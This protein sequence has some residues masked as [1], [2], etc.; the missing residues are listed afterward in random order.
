MRFPT[1]STQALVQSLQRSLLPL[2]AASLLAGPPAFAATSTWTGGSSSGNNFSD[3]ANWGGTAL[4]S[5]NSLLFAGSTRLTPNNDLTGLT[6]GGIYFDAAAGAFTLGGN[7]ITNTGNIVFYGNNNPSTLITQAVNFDLVIS[8]SCNI[9]S[10]SNG[11]LVV[12][13]TIS[14]YPGNYSASSIFKDNPGHVVFSGP[15]LNVNAIN[16]RQGNIDFGANDFH[17]NSLN[18]NPATGMTSPTQ[19][20]S[21]ADLRGSTQ[22]VTNLSLGANLGALNTPINLV[23][24]VGGGVL[25][26]AG[27]VTYL[28]GLSI[29]YSNSQATISAT[30][31]LNG[32]DRTFGIQ[33]S[34]ATSVD[35]L[36]NGAIINS[37]STAGIIKNN[38][39]VLVLAGTNTY[40]GSTTVNAG[41]LQLNVAL[42]DPA[43]TVSVNNIG[44]ANNPLLKLNF[45]DT[46]TVSAFYT[47]YVSL[48]DGV[49][50]A[51]NMPGVISGSGA[52]RVGSVTPTVTA[53]WLGGS[54]FTYN[55]SGQG[56][57]LSSV[58]TSP[59]SAGTTNVSYFGV[60][61][62]T[63]GPSANP[64]T[65]AGNYQV[66]VTIGASGNLTSITSSPYSFVIQSVADTSVSV[67]PSVPGLPASDQYAVRVCAA[68]N[69]SNWQSAFAWE[70]ADGTNYG[71]DTPQI[72]SYFSSLAGWTHTYV[73]FVA[74]TPVIVE[75][76]KV[77][78][79]AITKAAVH[80]ARMGSVIVANGKAYVTLSNNCNVAVDINGQMDDN[81]TG[82]VVTNPTNSYIGHYWQGPPINTISIHNNPPL[83]GVPATNDPS[84]YLV[85]PGSTPP[86]T[87]S[88]TTLYFLPGVHNIGIG[89]PI[90]KNKSYY[91]PGDALVYG[92]FC[93]Y[94]NW[95]DG[96]GIRIFGHGTL[97]ET[98]WQ[99][100]KYIATATNANWYHP[101]EI[102]GALNTSV[103]G[104]SIADPCYHS[105]MMYAAYTPGQYTLT[106]WVK[107]FGWR[108]NGDGYN[109]FGNG[110][111]HNCFLR[112]QDDSSYVNGVDMGGIVYWN[113]A[114]GSAFVLTGLPNLTNRT[115]LVHDCDVIYSRAYWINWSGSRV[116]NMRGVGSGACGSGVIFSNINVEDPR[117]TMQI[118]GCWMALTSPYGSGSRSPGDWSGTI[119]KNLNISVPNPNYQPEI[120]WGTN[121]A[122]IHDLTFDNLTVRGITVRTNIFTT[123]A[124]VYNL[125]FT[126]SAPRVI[127]GLSAGGGSLSFN[128]TNN[129]S[130]VGLP[131]TNGA[132]IFAV[133]NNGAWV[134]QGSSSLANPNGWIPIATNV[135]PFAFT[136]TNAM[137]G[138]PQRFYRVASP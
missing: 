58:T 110:Q 60:S 9:N 81:D 27:N 106:S 31:D 74:F 38:T 98:P 41:T 34:A 87:G 130:Y 4:A 69:G 63:C 109:P 16:V 18:L 75:I 93:N 42:L 64:P 62:T 65:N 91:I 30:L 73:N 124:Y 14:A 96:S 45:A 8:N 136:D 66:T 59:H 84:V 108:G 25:K 24:S 55:G 78:G 46:N 21:Q 111:I 134:V 94:T 10:Q 100:P 44:T 118:F 82:F 115:L 114:N 129:G 49:Y 128:I 26:L 95:N 72:D 32:A 83:A 90:H 12:S 43:A 107:V 97:S 102:S 7:A 123:N 51:A 1:R 56:P 116:F 57:T 50:N 80:P 89:F 68:S 105:V 15:A 76:S 33:D 104:I 88:W 121:N 101:I 61:G 112:T 29:S 85:T 113:D 119:F 17:L 135:A 127:T 77:D 39:G 20:I 125:R 5:G 11:T 79:S 103:E 2:C 28:G 52:L 132:S 67:F 48:P 122:Q 86:S 23:D 70:T 92:S 3:S 54:R 47:N 126:N 36:V 35:M 19:P 53:T 120:L 22:T 99:N 137:A 13:G 40:N 117:P 133:T 6:I 37:T 71:S 131:G 138:Y